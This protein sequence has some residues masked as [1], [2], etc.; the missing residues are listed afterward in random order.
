MRC[1]VCVTCVDRTNRLL[2]GI[3]ERFGGLE[4]FLEK[5]GRLKGPQAPDK[6]FLRGQP[7]V[8]DPLIA[9][10]TSLV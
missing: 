7:C 8:N 3:R 9:V 5:E 10:R 6:G 4:G 1:K 2:A